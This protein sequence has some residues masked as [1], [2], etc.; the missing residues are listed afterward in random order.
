MKKLIELKQFTNTTAGEMIAGLL[1]RAGGWVTRRR[2]TGAVQSHMTFIENAFKIPAWE[3]RADVPDW[4]RRTALVTTLHG[5]HYTG[6]VFNDYAKMLEILR[7]TATQIPAE[8]VIAFLSS[9]DG[10]YYWDYPNYQV[11]ERMGGETGLRKLIQEGQKLGFK[12]MLM[13]GANAANRRQPVWPKIA[14]GSTEEN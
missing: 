2:S 11:P 4:A 7:W 14:E 5:M 3:T 8:R 12:M 6:Y 10:R 13:F 9:W 1:F